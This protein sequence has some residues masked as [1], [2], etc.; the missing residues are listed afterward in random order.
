MCVRTA[1]NTVCT[2]KEHT[3]LCSL[4]LQPLLA[5]VVFHLMRLQVHLAVLQAAQ[6]V[7]HEAVGAA[8]VRA[9]DLARGKAERWHTRHSPAQ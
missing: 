1:M 4:R 5:A 8:G 9:T 6:D 3:A 2:L 7:R